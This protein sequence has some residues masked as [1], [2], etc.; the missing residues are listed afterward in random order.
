MPEYPPSQPPYAGYSDLHFATERQVR[1]HLSLAG[2]DRGELSSAPGRVTFRGMRV[3]VDCGGV[4]GISLVRKAFPWGI[5]LVVGLVAAALVYLISPVPFTW[6]QPLP[7]VVLL[8][9][10][11]GTVRYGNERWVE[12]VYSG[13]VGARRAY[14]RREP[15]FLGTGARRTVRL[16]REL[17]RS[18]LSDGEPG[19]AEPASV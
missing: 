16:Y 2:Y 10:V 5:V 3:L 17:R 13:G 14:F 6:R 19:P 4:T 1:S 7:G 11:A 12:V 8:V 18:V 9:L 15:M